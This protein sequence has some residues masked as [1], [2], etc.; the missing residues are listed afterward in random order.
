MKR[1]CDNCEKEYDADER[2]LKRGWGLCC[3]KSCAAQR[4]EKQ[5]PGYNP[6]IVADN[7]ARRANWNSIENLE[8]MTASQKSRWNYKKWGMDAPN[9]IGSSGII[10]G[11]TS[12]GYRIMDRVAYD[13]WDD[14][15]YNVTG[16]EDEGDSMY[17]DNSDNG[18]EF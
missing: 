1:K 3:S 7:N 2:N 15:V 17:W 11:I 16:E 9:V 4:R 12:E 5:K 14:P 6:A 13:E 18:N 10:T 8:N